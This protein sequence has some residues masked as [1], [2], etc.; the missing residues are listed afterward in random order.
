MKSTTIFKLKR[1]KIE[2][3][4]ISTSIYIYIN[5]LLI[6]K[7]LLKRYTDKMKISEKGKR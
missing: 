1:G 3:A 4:T 7:Y 6:Y 5:D 2:W